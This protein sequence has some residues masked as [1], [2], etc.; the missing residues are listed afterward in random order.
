M[1]LGA[2]RINEVV[3][4]CINQAMEV[5]CDAITNA[6]RTNLEALA[7][8]R[9][10]I[11]E[12]GERFA[13]AQDR[14]GE[15]IEA[16]I[17]IALAAQQS[18]VTTAQDRSGERIESAITTALT[19]QQS[20]VLQ[21]MNE[22]QQGTPKA[23]GGSTETETPKASIARG[24]NSE[25]HGSSHDA[26]SSPQS[27]RPSAHG[28]SSGKSINFQTDWNGGINQDTEPERTSV[29]PPDPGHDG[30]KYFIP[31][32]V[33][34][35]YA[36]T[37]VQP[38][39]TS[40]L[41][42]RSIYPWLNA[43]NHGALLTGMAQIPTVTVEGAR[44]MGNLILNHYSEDLQPG[45]MRV[46]AFSFERA[47]DRSAEFA[48]HQPS[49]VIRIDIMY[50]HGNRISK[51]LT[52]IIDSQIMNV[53]STPRA[54]L[55]D[56]RVDLSRILDACLVTVRVTGLSPDIYTL[57]DTLV[58][59]CR[60]LG[61]AHSRPQS[62]GGRFYDEDSDS[63]D[64]DGRHHRPHRRHESWSKSAQLE[65][66]SHFDTWQ[67]DRPLAEHHHNFITT[68]HSDIS[69][70]IPDLMKDP[71]PFETMIQVLLRTHT[72][73]T[74]AKV[75][76]DRPGTM[77][78][79]QKAF[80]KTKHG[81]HEDFKQCKKYPESATGRRG[82]AD[83]FCTCC[84]D[85]RAIIMGTTRSSLLCQEAMD[86]VQRAEQQSK[87]TPQDDY[88]FMSYV[89]ALFSGHMQLWG[90]TQALEVSHLIN[91]FLP[92]V[93]AGLSRER[94]QKAFIYFSDVAEDIAHNQHF[95]ELPEELRRH[96]SNV[97]ADYGSSTSSS[98]CYSEL[99]QMNS[100]KADEG[101]LLEVTTKLSRGDGYR[102]NR[103][104][105]YYDQPW[106]LMVLSTIPILR[107][108][109]REFIRTIIGKAQ[110]FLPSTT[111]AAIFQVHPEDGGHDSDG[112]DEQS[113]FQAIEPL[114]RIKWSQAE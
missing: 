8:L 110:H 111:T 101:P 103:A 100:N 50:K 44:R 51:E 58:I 74:L 80:A 96:F 85:I 114:R 49:G 21:L 107:I 10:A 39:V 63:A 89:D 36:I 54:R 99:A 57:S 55:H 86:L 24:C 59:A 65:I 90:Y 92:T 29:N 40:A 7:G 15:R 95:T 69:T 104:T 61:I 91:Q 94:Q 25:P 3:S 35:H 113:N 27:D 73:H 26:R 16:A 9:D 47:L 79:L 33:V 6:Q 106:D 60:A 43:S 70:N 109:W 13:T 19:A 112:A 87:V 88:A 67:S 34:N 76:L 108:F 30:C 45:S 38:S 64:E 14:S 72:G 41:L 22:F 105:Q 102:K 42:N 20:A 2:D 48:P 4:S 46:Y 32:L 93:V 75:T 66:L 62:G 68:L 5:T 71:T 31:L 1:G 84:A 56:T 98:A 97:I 78:I 82:V 18:A 11:V 23:G 81:F 28:L 17:T 12:Q 77:A 37:P 53:V 52:Q 83:A